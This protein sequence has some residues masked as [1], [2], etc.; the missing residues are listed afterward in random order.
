MEDSHAIDL[1]LDS[2]DDDSQSNT[3]F[4]VYDGHGGASVAK[5]AGERVHRR[6]VEDG[7]YKERRFPEALK[8]AFLGSD[9][10]MK[11]SPSFMRDPAGCTAVAALVTKDGRIFVANAGDSRSVISVK[12]EVKALSNDHKPQNELERT[13]IVNAGGFI[14]FGRVNGNLAL[15]RALGDFDYKKNNFIGPEEQIITANPEISEHQITEED[16]FL[17]IACDGIWD[18][19]SSQ[20]VINCIRLLVAQGKELPEVCEII[21]DHCLAPDTTSGAGIGCDNMTIMIIALLHGRTK[22][23]WYSWV[24]ER[25]KQGVGYNTP[26]DLPQLYSASRLMSFRARRQA[27]EDRQKRYADQTTQERDN[28]MGLSPFARILGGTGGISYQPGSNILSDSGV[29]MFDN[30]D[31]SDDDPMDSYPPS[32]VTKSLRQ[33][34]DELESE[35]KDEHDFQ[36]EGSDKSDAPMND[37]EADLTQSSPT[38]PDGK[39]KGKE[40]Q[41]QGEAPSPPKPASNGDAKPSQLVSEPGGDTPS[42]AVRAEGFLDSSES[43]LKV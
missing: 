21:C 11:N 15:A 39:G 36:K 37:L 28:S 43:P 18:C 8:N 13:R 40:R 22:E 27:V 14:E 2:Q 10:E 6:L 26:D 7:A 4:A 38:R 17:V 24:T 1:N 16:E 35:S 29:L 23:Q 3:F 20:Q 30:E 25:T 12:G 31:D 34:L 41:L 19:L 5:F 33:Q 32:S 9:A 42:D